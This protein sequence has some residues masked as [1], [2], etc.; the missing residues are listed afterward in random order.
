MPGKGPD[1]LG[2]DGRQLDQYD[3]VKTYDQ[4]M[5]RPD[6]DT[7]AKLINSTNKPVLIM[8]DELVNYLKDAKAE[9]IG[10]Q[11]LAE[12]TVS[13]FHT[14]TDVIVNSK[15]AMLIITLPGSESAYK[16]ESELLDNTR[17]KSKKSA[18]GKVHLPSRWSA[19]RSMMLSGNDCS[20]RRSPVCHRCS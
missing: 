18:D 6:A 1:Y 8:L 17:Q 16:E 3:M 2:G 20:D 11:N 5:R 14:L 10:K 19:R 9:N 13:F 15:N 12:V 7:L 4:E